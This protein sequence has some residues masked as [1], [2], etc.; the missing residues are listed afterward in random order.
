M[1]KPAACESINDVRNEIDRIDRAVV[2]LLSERQ[3]YVE[4][5][6]KFKS[7]RDSVIANDR[8]ESMCAERREWASELDLSPDFIEQLFRQLIQHNIEKE[9]KLLKK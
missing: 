5:I 9:L 3:G 8:Q 4:E 1:K 6:V 2:E 7:D